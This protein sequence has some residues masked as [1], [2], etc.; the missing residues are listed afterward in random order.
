MQIPHASEVLKRF[1]LETKQV[2]EQAQEE[3]HAL[4]S[5]AVV[6]A[7]NLY[8]D[9][10]I[11]SVWNPFELTIRSKDGSITL[12]LKHPT[13]DRIHK[14]SVLKPCK[15]VDRRLL[16]AATLGVFIRHLKQQG[17]S[18]ELTKDIEN[19]ENAVMAVVTINHTQLKPAK[20]K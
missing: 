16:I 18:A 10:P 12:E 6:D 15:D 2:R 7:I 19:G 1:K 17:Y 20:S 14:I 8:T 11:V 5:K 13:E 4:I 3:I 9:V